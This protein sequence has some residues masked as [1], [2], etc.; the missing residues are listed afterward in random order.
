MLYSLLIRDH[1]WCTSNFFVVLTGSWFANEARVLEAETEVSPS[2]ELVVLDHYLFSDY[3]HPE[4]VSAPLVATIDS[5]PSVD[6][7]VEPP[8]SEVSVEKH[9]DT[10]EEE[11]EFTGDLAEELSKLPAVFNLTRVPMFSKY[12]ADA[13]VSELL[14]SGERSSGRL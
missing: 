13:H 12:L 4:E 14:Q 9:V 1:C 7:P 8:V 11:K 6:D 3:E 10:E 5:G 2:G